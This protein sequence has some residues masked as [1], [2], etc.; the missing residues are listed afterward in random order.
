MEMITDEN[1]NENGKKN[2]WKWKWFYLLPFLY[3]DNYR[4]SKY[5]NI[6]GLFLYLIHS[7]EPINFS[8]KYLT[9]VQG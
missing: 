7:L 6:Y 3:Y 5:T 2:T 1:R 9:I 4:I 8:T